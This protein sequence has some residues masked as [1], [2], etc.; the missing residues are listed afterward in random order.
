MSLAA[1]EVANFLIIVDDLG[2]RSI[3]SATS[4]IWFILEQWKLA[5]EKWCPQLERPKASSNFLGI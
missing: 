1:M 5:T 2:L 3:G 4:G